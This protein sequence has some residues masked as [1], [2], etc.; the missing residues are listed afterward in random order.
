MYKLTRL[1]KSVIRLFMPVVVTVVVMVM[2][3]SVWLVHSTSIPPRNAYLV[4]PEVYGRLSSHAAQVTEETWKNR[5]GTTARGWLLRGKKDYPAVILLHKYGADRS[6]VLNLGVKL[7]EETDFTVL[8]PDQR[9]HGLNP[10][11]KTTSFG[12][13]EVEDSLAAIDYLRGLRDSQGNNLVGEDIGIYGVEMGAFT[14]LATAAKD[15]TVKAVALD[16]VPKRSDDLI[17]NVISKRYPFLSSVTSRMAE[18]A[19]YLYYARGCYERKTA[20]EL[21]GSVRERNALLLSGLDVPALKE[22]TDKMS[23]CFPPTTRVQALTDLSA[24]GV[25]LVN[26]SPDKADSY[27]QKVIYFFQENLK[28]PLPPEPAPVDG[29]ENVEVQV[30][31]AAG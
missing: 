15:Q 27:D 21:A 5:D 16:S 12:G 24:S 2:A 11:V 31:E 23:G 10:P 29:S 8:M 6:Y 4:T 30:T 17:D 18:S 26:V 20:C 7:S 13:C 14:G 28:T 1:I 25:D 9:G 3:A 19:T 22:A